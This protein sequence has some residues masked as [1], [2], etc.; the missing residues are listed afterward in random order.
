MQLPEHELEESWVVLPYLPACSKQVIQLAW[1]SLQQWGGTQREFASERVGTPGKRDQVARAMSSKSR[2]RRA[3]RA[4]DGSAAVARGAVV[5]CTAPA[6]VRAA[7]QRPPTQRRRIPS[8]HTQMG[9][10][11]HH[12]TASVSGTGRVGKGFSLTGGAGAGRGRSRSRRAGKRYERKTAHMR[13]GE[14]QQQ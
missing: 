4:R 5:P 11:G 3:Y 12:R 7:T 14:R 1:A 8:Q 9:T 2:S 13:F 6:T 10:R